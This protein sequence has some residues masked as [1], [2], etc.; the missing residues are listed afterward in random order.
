MEFRDCVAKAA[1]YLR[2]S[3]KYWISLVVLYGAIAA[4]FLVVMRQPRLFSSVMRRVPDATMAVFPFKS[5]WYVARA[6]RL[7]VG[8][9]AP[10]FGLPA[11]DRQSTVSLASFR[12]Q[13]PVV[14]VF[15]SYT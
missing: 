9:Q 14:L 13:K 6:G 8:D 11:A 4:G 7:R 10:G 2:K 5:L 3:S 15:G 1:L 12:G